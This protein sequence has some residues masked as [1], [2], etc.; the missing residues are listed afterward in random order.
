MRESS[1]TDGEGR[2]WRVLLPSDES[3]YY[4]ERGIRIGPIDVT[5]LAEARGWPRDFQMRLHNE[6]FHRHIN[7]TIPRRDRAALAQH[8]VQAIIA[9]LKVDAKSILDLDAGG[10]P[11]LP[12][13]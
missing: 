5:P 4:A 2:L 6:L 12:D 9:A 7:T 13:E 8:V 1:Y 3:D 11:I 10:E